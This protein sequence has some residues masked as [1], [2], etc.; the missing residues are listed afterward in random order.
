MLGSLE[1]ALGGKKFGLDDEIKEAMRRTVSHAVSQ[2]IFLFPEASGHLL[3][4]VTDLH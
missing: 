3:K 4:V 1:E 2:K